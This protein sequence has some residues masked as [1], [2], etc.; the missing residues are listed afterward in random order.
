MAAAA[1]V[2]SAGAARAQTIAEILGFKPERQVADE[3]PLDAC[4]DRSLASA[5]CAPGTPD[6]SVQLTWSTFRLPT[7][8]V[9]AVPFLDGA[10]VSWE[11]E[12]L[13]ES[14]GRPEVL[15]AGHG[16]AVLDE[17]AWTSF[18]QRFES[19]AWTVYVHDARFVMAD[20]EGLE[21]EQV[22]DGVYRRMQVFNP[23]AGPFSH[24]ATAILGLA[25]PAAGEG[26][27][28]G[29]VPACVLVSLLGWRGVMPEDGAMLHR[30]LELACSRGSLEGCAAVASL[31]EPSQRDMQVLGVSSVL[32]VRVLDTERRRQLCEK[33]RSE[34]GPCPSDTDAGRYCDERR[35]AALLALVCQP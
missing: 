27:Q 8:R 17:E 4:E 15:R 7:V 30:G 33:L 11:L 18:S 2:S 16:G 21:L 22:E 32:T 29:E 24:V 34:A 3:V 10:I 5:L 25:A 28:R 9:V 35:A 14:R 19:L 26:C 12:L 13:R 1:L 31:G 20:G 23:E 6:G